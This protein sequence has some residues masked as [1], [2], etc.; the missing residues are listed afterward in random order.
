MTF[1][2]YGKI[3]FMF[4]TTNQN[5]M[6]P[7]WIPIFKST[8]IHVNPNFWSDPQFAWCFVPVRRLIGV[9]LG[10]LRRWQWQ[11]QRLAVQ[12]W[13]VLLATRRNVSHT[14][15]G[16]NVENIGRS[17]KTIECRKE[18][19]IFDWGVYIYIY[20]YYIEIATNIAF[21]PQEKLWSQ[22]ENTAIS[23][24]QLETGIFTIEPAIW[25][26]LRCNNWDQWL[27]KQTCD[28]N[29]K[30]LGFN[31]C[32]N[33][34]ELNSSKNVWWCRRNMIWNELVNTFAVHAWNVSLTVLPRC[35]QQGTNVSWPL[36]PN[37]D[38]VHPVLDVG[39]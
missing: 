35:R 32:K 5:V 18:P 28:L 17:T 3:K 23:P 25:H 7:G 21:F 22:P 9:A 4:Q 16:A 12:S 20:T 11:W 29:R 6:F 31:H 10:C 36:N 30:R 27:K 33:G 38:V 14:F 24:L 2:I 26:D 19:S 1:P 34:L 8:I 13:E 39:V 15:Y 37:H